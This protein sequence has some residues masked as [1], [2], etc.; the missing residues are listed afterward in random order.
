MPR[1]PDPAP[2][3]SDN[4]DFF[5]D[6]QDAWPSTC[7]C[8]VLGG[9]DDACSLCRGLSPEDSCPYDD[10]IGLSPAAQA[11]ASVRFQPHDAQAVD[12]AVEEYR[13]RHRR[14]VPKSSKL[15]RLRKT[16]RRS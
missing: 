1:R 9:C 14:E 10:G 5:G 12:K 11:A 8:T 4:A 6:Y 15:A 16:F 7:I 13:G 3:G 2:F